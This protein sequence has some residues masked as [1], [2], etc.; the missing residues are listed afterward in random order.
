[1]QS[2]SKSSILDMLA[3]VVMRAEL[4]IE[5]TEEVRVYHDFLLSRDGMN[6]FDAT[7]MRL[8]TIGEVM[9]NVDAGTEGC[10]LALYP[11]IPWR[12][13]CGLRNIISHEYLSIDPEII[14]SVVKK[15]LRP[16]LISL[17]QI[18]SNIEAGHHDD[19]FL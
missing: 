4:A 1:M 12:K 10:L 5:S 18:I 3:F 9:K 2:M 7:C 13:I 8:Q 14:F 17:K 15:H 6:L 19:L 16:M 11:E